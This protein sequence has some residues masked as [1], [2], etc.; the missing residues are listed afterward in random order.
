MTTHSARHLPCRARTARSAPRCR[1]GAVADLGQT[2]IGAAPIARH[3]HAWMPATPRRASLSD[4]CS[5]HRVVSCHRVRCTGE[6]GRSHPSASRANPSVSGASGEGAAPRFCATLHSR[7][8]RTCL[9]VATSRRG[10]AS[11]TNDAPKLQ[12]ASGRSY[13]R[14]VCSVLRK[15]RRPEFRV[16]ACAPC[17]A[18]G[19]ADHHASLDDCRPLSSGEKA[20]MI[21]ED[22]GGDAVNPV[23]CCQNTGRGSD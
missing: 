16:A 17:A 15:L 18:T 4:H 10:S 12:R 14:Q 19:R 1:E 11:T 8:L 9:T 13:R 5:A 20:L 3:R 2:R 23:R 21:R 6:T 22:A 7:C